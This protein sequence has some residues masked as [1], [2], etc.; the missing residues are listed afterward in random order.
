MVMGKKSNLMGNNQ[1]FIKGV[2][3][4]LVSCLL[5]C[6]EN[7]IEEVAPLGD[8]SSYKKKD[9][10]DAKFIPDTVI[11]GQLFLSSEASANLDKNQ[12]MQLT[13]GLRENPVYVF[14]NKHEDEYLLGYQ[15]EGS[16]INKFDCFE[17]GYVKNLGLN[18]AVVLENYDSFITNSGL[19]IGMNLDSLIKIKGKLH[20]AKNDVNIRY[21]ISD[22][23]T[24]LFLQRYNMPAYF[25]ECSIDSQIVSKIKFG[26]IQ[27]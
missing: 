15:Y 26:F 2:L 4:L 20:V 10:G 24:N 1:V 7:R 23:T 8:S 14:F 11:N 17:I 3:P 21:Q 5:S 25:L 12:R 13:E 18:K 27:P 19:R 6:N 9:I 16:A 22:Y